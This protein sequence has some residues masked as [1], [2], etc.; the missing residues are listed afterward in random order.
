MDRIFEDLATYEDLDLS[1]EADEFA[2]YVA[3]EARL[4]LFASMP[5][6]PTTPIV[7]AYP[8]PEKD[9]VKVKAKAKVTP[10]QILEAARVKAAKI[11]AAAEKKAAK[12]KAKAK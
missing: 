8:E 3:T 1:E 2:E 6:V 12:V 9:K 10:A 4:R 11:I 5:A 7:I